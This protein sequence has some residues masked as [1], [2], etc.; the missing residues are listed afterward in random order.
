MTIARGVAAVVETE[1]NPLNLIVADRFG[2][3]ESTDSES[4]HLPFPPNIEYLIFLHES[5]NC[6]NRTN[7]HRRPIS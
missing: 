7:P 3:K 5:D 1:K 4:P 2:G 6:F